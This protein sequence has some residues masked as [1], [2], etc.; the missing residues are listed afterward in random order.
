MP[1]LQYDEDGGSGGPEAGSDDG[2][3][4]DHPGGCDDSSGVITFSES[5]PKRG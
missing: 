1:V 4:G 5:E 3:G 2:E